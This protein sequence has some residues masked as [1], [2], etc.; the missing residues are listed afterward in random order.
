MVITAKLSILKDEEAHI[1]L[2]EVQLDQITQ[3]GV[4]TY[5]AEQID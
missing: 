4:Q 3:V 1:D 5:L 2:I